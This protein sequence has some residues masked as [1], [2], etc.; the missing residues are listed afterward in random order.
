MML[1]SVL[2]FNDLYSQRDTGS[3]TVITFD[4]EK[5]F[6][7]YRSTSNL[8]RNVIRFDVYA[9]LIGDYSLYY[10]RVLNTKFSLEFG[11]G[12]TGKN[13]LA[14]L[15]SNLYS[16]GPDLGQFTES[17]NT[18]NALGSTFK[19]GLK[20]YPG[21]FAPEEFYIQVQYAF[22]Q[23]NELYKF[24]T[25]RSNLSNVNDLNAASIFNELRLLFGSAKF[26]G[27]GD[28]WMGDL[29]GGIGMKARN[30]D[31]VNYRPDGVT[32]IYGYN[33]PQ[34]RFYT[35]SVQDIKLAIY[36]GWKIGYAF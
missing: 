18:S 14:H 30:I 17:Y 27:S 2:T 11:G 6:D 20:F 15:Y 8:A 19:C 22:R 28:R 21:A 34:Y 25:A 23:Y 3:T 10:E 26:F 1:L 32:N 9:I 12:L 24:N 36:L 7:D 13:W 33:E 35:S 29:F 5:T 16:S 31:E 4:D